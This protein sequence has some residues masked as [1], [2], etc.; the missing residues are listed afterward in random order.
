MTA[1][2]SD[3]GRH[4][5]THTLEM[6]Q[7]VELNLRLANTRSPVITAG[8]L[9]MSSEPG[10]TGAAVAA[11]APLRRVSWRGS[12]EFPEIDGH[13]GAAGH[14][15]SAG[16]HTAALQQISRRLLLRQRWGV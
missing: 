7:I 4:S 11:D 10:D 2:A 8:D 12:P 15:V 9:G 1:H 3:H 5:T 13:F 14:E 6:A 16:L